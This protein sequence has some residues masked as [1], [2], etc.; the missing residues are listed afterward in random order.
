[1]M[2]ATANKRPTVTTSS[3][4]RL[5]AT[6]PT[7]KIASPKEWNAETFVEGFGT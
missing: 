4:E 2:A 5:G 1:M 6:S 7:V 3:L